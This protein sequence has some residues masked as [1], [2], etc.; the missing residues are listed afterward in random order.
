MKLG[1][2]VPAALADAIVR[3][4]AGG[5]H[6]L[7]DAWATRDALVIFVRHF[8]CAGCAEHVAALRPR[9]AELAQLGVEAIVVGNGTPDQLAGF[10]DREAIAAFTDP[11][12]AA[13][14]AAE[15]VR[16]RWSTYGPR[17]LVQLA[18]A[19]L[20]G[21][22]NGRAQGDPIQQGGTLYIARGGELCFY[23]RAE[24]TGDHAS[25]GDVVD[26]A[27]ARRAVEAAS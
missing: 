12:L 16:S 24:A 3:D 8:A 14:R 19:M 18:G 6:R 13:Y 17:A 4:A 1:E 27:L 2:P 15:L 10:V 22:A 5:E 9:L 23:S 7:G 11:S 25:L 26:V 20:R 21:F